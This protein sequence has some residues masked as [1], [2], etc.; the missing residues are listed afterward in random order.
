MITP[1]FL[2]TAT[3]N[4]EPKLTLDFTSA[5][6]DPSVTFT[7]TTNATNPATYVD[8][9]GLIVSA[10]DNQPRFDYNL[11]T[12]GDCK[13]LLI[14]ESRT[15]LIENS[16]NFQ[17]SSAWSSLGTTVTTDST[18]TSPDGTLNAA[19]VAGAT[20][21]TFSGNV[22]RVSRG[23]LSSSTRY[24]VSVYI[25]LLTA[26]K[27]TLYI[28]DSSTGGVSSANAIATSDWQRVVV[29][30]LAGASTTGM[31]SYIGNTDGD[32]AVFGSQFELGATVSSYIPT[33]AT[34]LTRNADVAVMTGTDF[35]DWYNAA[36]GT[37]RVDAISPASGS[38]ASGIRPIISADDNTADESLIVNTD[39]TTPKFIVTESA[40]EQAN[41]SAGTVV[42]NTPMFAYVS[43]D[44]NFFGIARPTARQVD[45][46]GTVPTVDRLRIGANQAGSYLNGYIRQIQFWP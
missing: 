1:N 44:A 19:T 5:S 7:R 20:G 36:K 24:F 27:A 3:E 40:S 16:T 28:R 12:G 38:P 14:E 42:A 2:L 46:S 29:S 25:K 4:V 17:I 30:R 26:T 33:G 32:I 13:G 43:Y 9:N 15:N 41:V 18:V 31:I 45:T 23:S 37:F 11:N 34:P 8:S 35:S 39:D 22:L 6:L 10:S 21:T